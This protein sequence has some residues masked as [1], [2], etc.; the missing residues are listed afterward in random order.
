MLHR[1][2]L[3]S[4]LTTSMMIHHCWEGTGSRMKWEEVETVTEE[5]EQ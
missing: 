4:L 1:P 5:E 3:S 2:L